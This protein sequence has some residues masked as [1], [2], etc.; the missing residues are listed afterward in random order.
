MGHWCIFLNGYTREVIQADGSSVFLKNVGDKVTLWF[1]L[2][3]DLD[4]LNGDENLIINED[5]NGY[6]NMFE[7]GQTDFGRG[8]L[9]ISYRDY[10]GEVHDPVIYT[11]YLAANTRTGV[12]PR[13]QLF[14]EGD[15]WIGYT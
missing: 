8:T 15:Y 9:I 2:E 7:I 5:S 4:A 10:Q 1:N 14:E 11:N 13:V 3:Q 6:D 12:D